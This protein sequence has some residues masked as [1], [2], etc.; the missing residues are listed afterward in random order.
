MKHQR[1]RRLGVATVT[2]AVADGDQRGLGLEKFDDV[3]VEPGQRR[4]GQRHL[5][6]IDRHRVGRAEQSTDGVQQ[7]V[8][9]FG[10][11]GS[12][13]FGSSSAMGARERIF[14]RQRWRVGPTLPRG[15]PIRCP[16]SS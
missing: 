7:F 1:S 4:N 12:D 16:I 2:A 15:I 13:L 10:N 6:H 9:G 3:G 11:H 5:H 14:F 8:V